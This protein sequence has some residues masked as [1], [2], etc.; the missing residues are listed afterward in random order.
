MLK[1]KQ[2]SV[3]EYWFLDLGKGKAIYKL[4]LL[5]VGLKTPNIIQLPPK[6]KNRMKQFMFK[7]VGS[8]YTRSR[9]QNESYTKKKEKK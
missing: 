2:K 8:P 4:T 7:L 9:S 1:E 5:G 3:A 6:E